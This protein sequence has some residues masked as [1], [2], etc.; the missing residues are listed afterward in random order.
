[1]TTVACN[2]KEMACDLQYTYGGTTKFKG[3]PKVIEVPESTCREVFGVKKALIGFCGTAEKFALVVEWL[4]DP[5]EKP[6]KLGK[7]FEMLMLNDRGEIYH[8]TT[9]VNW[10]RLHEECFAV[11]SGMQYAM[12]AMQLGKTPAEGVKVAA[13]YDTGTGMGIKTYTI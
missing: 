12:S 9:V 11:G 1:M 5:K 3:P 2:K 7:N 13:K 4:H 6:P 8:A 10:L